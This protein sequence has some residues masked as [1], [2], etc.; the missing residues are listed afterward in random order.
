MNISNPLTFKPGLHIVS[1]FPGLRRT[2]L[3]RCFK[4]YFKAVN[5]S[6]E[7][8]SCEI[9]KLVIIPTIESKPY[10]YILKYTFPTNCLRSLRLIWRPGFR[11]KTFQLSLSMKS[12]L[13]VNSSGPNRFDSKSKVFQDI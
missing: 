12:Q 11:V 10:P 1:W 3:R 9:S 4:E 8:N 6:I 2:C 7:N 5:I 13:N